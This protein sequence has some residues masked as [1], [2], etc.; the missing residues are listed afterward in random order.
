MFTVTGM[1][2]FMIILL[3]ILVNNLSLDRSNLYT[4]SIHVL[5]PLGIYGVVQLIKVTVDYINNVLLDKQRIQF[6]NF[7]DMNV[8]KKCEEIDIPYY[9]DFNFYNTI[10]RI[11]EGKTSFSFVF[12]RYIIFLNNIISV[13]LAA[14]LLVSHVSIFVCIIIILL[15]IPPLVTRR[16]FYNKQ[17][18][19]EKDSE[20]TKRKIRYL[21]NICMGKENS[22]EIRFFNFEDHIINKYKT[23]WNE[24]YTGGKKVLKKYG[25][26]DSFINVIP[27]VGV[28]IIMLT[29]TKNI[30]N[31]NMQI[32]DFIFVLTLCLNLSNSVIDLVEDLSRFGESGRAISEYKEFMHLK[33]FVENSGK[34]VLDSID[35]IEFKNISFRYPNSTTQVLDDISF[36]I[37]TKERTAIV[38]VNGAGKTTIMKLIMRFYDATKGSILIN[39]IDIIEYDLI[40]LRRQ[41]SCV[42]Q[43]YYIFNSSIRD[44]ITIS[45]LSKTENNELIFQAIDDAQLSNVVKKENDFLDVEISKMFDP[46]GLELS[47]GQRQKL[48]IARGMFKSASI[49]ILDESTASLDPES[50]KEILNNEKLSG[51]RAGILM[52][53][54]R[55]YNTIN[56]DNVVVIENGKV[57]ELGNPKTLLEN[58]G[59][60]AYLYN[61]QLSKFMKEVD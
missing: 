52:I 49:V 34:M 42:L 45:D 57:V 6:N 3:K 27:S 44:N 5:I 17:F 25:I 43:E 10:T 48:A 9:D 60:Y 47:G 54:H 23:N 21:A 40:S 20:A 51:K 56:M 8:I 37:S 7:I 11:K 19:Y 36:T 29:I 4:Y 32:G 24:Y 13:I 53:S 2:Y 15:S 46:Q 50:E 59:R 18:E 55:L 39:S 26:I 38:G 41:V 35:K 16:L 30:L 28:G 31:E 58:Q 12:F 33:P 14:V 1:N 22:K 61:L